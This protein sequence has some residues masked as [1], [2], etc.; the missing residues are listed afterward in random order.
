MKI[1]SIS[2]LVEQYMRQGLSKLFKTKGFLMHGLLK[3]Q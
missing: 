1:T 2:K 3:N